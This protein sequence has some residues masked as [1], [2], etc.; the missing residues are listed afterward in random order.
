MKYIIY[1]T[2]ACLW[3]GTAAPGLAGKKMSIQVETGQVREKPSVFGKVIKTIPY[4]ERIEIVKKQ[5]PWM[6]PCVWV[7]CSS[8]KQT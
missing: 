2:A 4:G 3:L 6:L 5:S 1:M 7:A 8:A